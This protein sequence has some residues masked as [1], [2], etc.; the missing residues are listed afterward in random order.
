MHSTLGKPFGLPLLVQESVDVAGLGSPK[1]VS[2][3]TKEAEDHGPRLRD[4]LVADA[5]SRRCQCELVQEFL[6]KII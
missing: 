3:M 5:G 4:V 2:E 1:V 6:L